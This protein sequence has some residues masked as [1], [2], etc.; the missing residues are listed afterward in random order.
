M[1]QGTSPAAGGSQL[2]PI[3]SET[4]SK[5]SEATGHRPLEVV[6][7]DQV[8]GDACQWASYARR[9]AGRGYLVVA[10]DFRFE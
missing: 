9:L 2:N 3:V 8:R 4:P 10:F 7:A 5:G 6:L 1:L